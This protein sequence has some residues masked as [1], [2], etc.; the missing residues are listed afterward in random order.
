VL[1]LLAV[2]LLR[3]LLLTLILTL[4]PLLLP[5]LLGLAG[6]GTS[7]VVSGGGE[8]TIERLEELTTGL[9]VSGL[10]RSLVGI[11]GTEDDFSGV[12]V[13]Q[14]FFSGRHGNTHELRVFV[15]RER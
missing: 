9:N 7:S 12:Y 2:L 4:L 6:C 13:T 8:G 10:V 3:L 5:L 1:V 11:E 14:E 15:A